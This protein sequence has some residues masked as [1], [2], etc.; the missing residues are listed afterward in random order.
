VM[1]SLKPVEEELS[2][3]HECNLLFDVWQQAALAQLRR[4]QDL[5]AGQAR[6][7]EREFGVKRPRSALTSRRR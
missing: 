3:I 6:V 7:T 4:L 2:F 1:R 5:R